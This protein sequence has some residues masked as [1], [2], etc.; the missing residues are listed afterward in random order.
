MQLSGVFVGNP[1]EFTKDEEKAMNDEK[2][3]KMTIQCWS[4]RGRH[5]RY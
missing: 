4:L 5:G 1:V 3:D 2:K